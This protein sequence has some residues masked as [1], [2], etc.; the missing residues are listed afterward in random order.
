[1]LTI[2][3]R[4]WRRNDQDRNARAILAAAQD[5]A[6]RVM[7]F[8]SELDAVGKGLADARDAYDAALKRLS[9]PD[10]RARSVKAALSALE[11][12]K[13]KSAKSMPKSLAD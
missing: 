8:G 6:D 13:V 10:G 3:E 11:D 1:M 9:S 4:V 12:L 5:L 2:I 7:A